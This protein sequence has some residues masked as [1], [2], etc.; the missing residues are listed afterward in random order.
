M[1]A[2]R[3]KDRAAIAR[4]FVAIAERFGA[5]IE[6]REE[7]RNIGYCGAGICLQFSLNGVGA[8]VSISDLHGGK[9]ALVSC[10][11]MRISGNT[12]LGRWSGIAPHGPPR[13]MNTLHRWRNCGQ[14]MKPARTLCGWW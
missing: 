10:P 1:N 11:A 2:S 6:R 5:A 7:P 9:E 12:S 14:S 13:R 8:T 3:K 4:D